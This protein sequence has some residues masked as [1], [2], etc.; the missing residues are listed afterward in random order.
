MK[1]MRAVYTETLIELAKSDVSIVVVEADLMRATGTLPFKAV[2]PNRAVDVG[3]AEANMLGVAAG[4]AA[5]GK[6]PFAATFG[7]FASRRAFDQFF[8]S[9]A[10][11]RLPVKLVGTDPGISAAFNGGT[12]MPFEDLGI[13]RMV[14]GLDIIEPS[15]PISLAALVRKLAASGK[16]GYMRLHRK[17]IE[18][19]YAEEE[20]FELGKGKLLRKGRDAVIVALGAIMVPEALAAARLLSGQ[21]IEAAVIDALSVKPLD[22]ALLMEWIGKTGCVVTAENHQMAGGLGSAVA[23]LIA[24]Q[25]FDGFPCR[26]PKLARVGVADEFGEVGTQDWLK[27]R[28][29]LDSDHIASVVKNLITTTKD[30]KLP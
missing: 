10:Y 1:E 28:F 24:E 19:I 21:G 17:A 2:Y 4:L 11:A 29:G 7:C 14:P 26:R 20:Q 3:V 5:E 8:L 27:T 18:P 23:E 13:M 6:I 16:P 25:D 12:H 9:G 30:R 22:I 15:D